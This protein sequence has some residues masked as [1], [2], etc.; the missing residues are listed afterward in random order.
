MNIQQ[1]DRFTYTA[2]NGQEQTIE[3]VSTIGPHI[4]Y[5]HIQGSSRSGSVHE[6]YFLTLI[7]NKYFKEV[8]A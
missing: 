1:G 8:K 4:G 5:K 2:T 7:E 3:V 6:D